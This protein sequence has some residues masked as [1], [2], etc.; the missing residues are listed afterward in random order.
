MYLYEEALIKDINKLFT[1]SKVCAVVADS[2]NEGLK[3]IASN[4]ED[5]ITLPT[6]VVIGG[7]WRLEDANFYSL[8]HGSEYNRIIDNPEPESVMKSTSILPITPSYSMIVIAQSSRECDMLTRELLFHY[9][10]NPT[11]TID[12]PYGINEAHTFNLLFSNNVTKNQ[13][14]TGLIYRTLDFIIQGA[15]LWH[16]D[17]FNVVRKIEPTVKEVYEQN[18]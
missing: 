8:M 17:T 7:N 10:K 9:S 15:Y 6:V 14:S 5:K 1:N 16:N 18:V 12:I 13:N 11:L 2:I 4:K 3:R